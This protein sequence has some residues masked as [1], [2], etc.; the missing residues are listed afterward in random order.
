V[1]WEN[2]PA[3]ITYEK[4]AVLRG[5]LKKEEHEKKLRKCEG[6]TKNFENVYSDFYWAHELNWAHPFPIHFSD[7][8]P[9]ITFGEKM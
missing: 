6:I 3:Y 5:N 9:Q 7:F 4:Y 8:V 1:G 2:I